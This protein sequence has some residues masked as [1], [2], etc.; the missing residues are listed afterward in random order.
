MLSA[1]S[2]ADETMGWLGNF[3]KPP[4]MT[5]VV[6]GEPEAAD[7]LRHRIDEELGWT[8]RRART[9]RRSRAG[10]SAGAA[11]GASPIPADGHNRLA[12]PAHGH[13]D[14]ARSPCLHARRLPCLPLGRLFLAEQRARDA[15]AASR[16]SPRSMS[17]PPTCWAKA[18][19]G[20]S[21][22]P[23]AKLKLKP[24]SV[25][26]A[27]AIRRRWNPSAMCAA[28]SMATGSATMPSRRSSSDIAAGRYPEHRPV[29]LHH[30]LRGQF[31]RPRRDDRADARHGRCRRA[32]RLGPHTDRR[33]ALRRRAARQP[34]DA[35]RGGDRRRGRA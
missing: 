35:D 23:W 34:H 13:R 22:Y 6:H 32:H 15:M 19:S 31:A 3:K 16:S 20:L 29:G 28:R 5:F 14:A 27:S 2:D 11:G 30:H 21:E 9:S 4:K 1:H 33:Q 17:S 7:A 25:G 10:M 24:G 26:H 18:R 8:R 12:R